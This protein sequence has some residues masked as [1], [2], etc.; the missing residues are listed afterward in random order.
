MS[1][2]PTYL[3][4][5]VTYVMCNVMYNVL[6]KTIQSCVVLMSQDPT[7]KHVSEAHILNKNHYYYYYYNY[8]YYYF[9]FYNIYIY[10]LLLYNLYMSISFAQKLIIR[11]KSISS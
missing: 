11:F 2:N 8:Y 4:C 6:Y 1:Q 10:V 7:E 5:N 9:Y 3:M